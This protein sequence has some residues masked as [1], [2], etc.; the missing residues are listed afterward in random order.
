MAAVHADLSDTSLQDHVLMDPSSRMTWT[1]KSQLDHLLEGDSEHRQPAPDLSAREMQWIRRSTLLLCGRQTSS[2][3]VKVPKHHSNKQEATVIM[4]T[5]EVVLK[6]TE[7]PSRS[8]RVS[9]AYSFVHRPSHLSSCLCVCL[10]ASLRSRRSASASLCLGVSS[11]SAPCVHCKPQTTKLSLGPD[12]R[13]LNE[14]PPNVKKR[15]SKNRKSFRWSTRSSREK[16]SAVTLPLPA[17]C[18]SLKGTRRKQCHVLHKA[19][20]PLMI[21]R[22][23]S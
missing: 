1:L 14:D 11:Q 4:W 17:A 8:T 21:C 19:L 2:S 20:T 9:E 10:A 23:H 7:G 18:N 12:E 22:R 3:C 16:P 15:R 6:V 5:T 13:T